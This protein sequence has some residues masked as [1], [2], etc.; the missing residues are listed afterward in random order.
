MAG[1][2]LVALVVATLVFRQS[3]LL[4]HHAVPFTQR[5]SAASDLRMEFPE[6]MDKPSVEENVITP[7]DVQ[8]SLRWDGN[9]LVFNPDA[10]LEE[11]ATYT[12]QVGRAAK[13]TN[14]TPLGRDL[15]FRFQVSGEPT[16]TARVPNADAVDVP[17]D[18]RISVVFDRPVV[19]LTQVQGK[20]AEDLLA[21]VPVR[22]APDVKGTFRWL[23]TYTLQFIPEK[24]LPLATRFTVS[25]PAGIRT[26]SGDVTA[27]DHSW[28]F[29]TERPRAVSSVPADGFR[30]AGPTT[31]LSISFN[32]EVDVGS[33]REHLRLQS[34]DRDDIRLPPEAEN[35]IKA[36]PEYEQDT[37]RWNQLLARMGSG[38]EV[39]VRDVRY[40]TTTSD[41]GKTVTDRKTVTIVPASS[42]EFHHLY[43]VRVLPGVRGLE[44]NLGSSQEFASTFATVGP[45]RV[46]QAMYEHDTIR[47]RFSNPVASGS[48]QP[49]IAL[50]P[51]PAGW[52]DATFDLDTWNE[53]RNLSIYPTLTPS[54]EYK[55]T[56]GKTVKDAFGQTLEKPHTFSFTTP[57]LPPSVSITSKGE[58][59]IFE[60]GKSPVYYVKGVNITSFEADFA[61]LTLADFLRLRKSARHGTVAPDAIAPLPGHQHWS[62]PVKTKHNEWVT[63]PLDPE[64]RA[65]GTLAPGI[66]A[67]MVQAPEYKDTS[68][69]PMTELQFFALTN[70]GLTLKYSG[71]RALVWATDLQ[72]GNP[73]AGAHVA[74][75]S[76]T[77]R[78]PVEGRTDANGFFETAIN[79]PDFATGESY[80]WIPEFWVTAEKDGDFAFVGSDWQD[81]IRPDEFGYWQ[82]FQGLQS[83]PLQMQSF[84]Y[85][86]RPLYA[87]GD[88]VH[89]KGVVRM[90]D[91]NGV[92]RLP[93]AARS[94]Q[95]TVRDENGTEVY[96]K[97]LPLNAFGSFTDSFPLSDK[98]ALGT[99]SLSMTLV[100]DADTSRGSG[101][102]ASF[103]VLAYRKPEY[104]VEVDVAAPD[105]FDRE[106]AQAQVK[107]SYYFGAPMAGAKVQWRAQTTDWFFNRYT[108]GWYS[109]STEDAWCWRDCERE[110]G[111]L[112]EG[113]GT[114]DAAGTM[115]VRVPMS[116]SDKA[117]SQILTI[118]ADVTDANNQ[119][120]SARE[121]VPVH[122]SKVYVGVRTS[123]YVVAPGQKARIDVVTVGIDGSAAPNRRVELA[124]FD[125]KWITTRKKGVDGEYYYDNE[126]ED[127]FLSN[128]SITTGGNGKGIGEFLIDRG[129][130]M[131][132]VATV[133][134]EDGREAKASTSVYAWSST[135]VNW[136]HANNDRLVM[137]VD[138]PEYRVGDIA[139]LLVKSPFQG[140]GVKALVTVERE[141]VMT[142]RVL[143]VTSNAQPIEV[144][145]TD[146]MI[147]NAFVSV[148][149]IKPREGET[150]DK[151]TGL[152]TGA[153]AFRIGY[154]KLNVE[155]KSKVLSVKVQTDK[156]TY[157][158]GETVRVKL[159]TADAT[160]KPAKAELSLGVVDMSLLALTGF[161]MPDPV[162]LFYNE[163]GLGV[164]TAEMLMYLLERY[165]PG[166][167][168][169][170][171][172]ALE[173][174]K[175]GDFRDTAYWN[176]VILTDE[177]GAASLTFKLPDNLTTWKLLAVGSTQKNL[178]GAGTRDVVETKHVIVRPVRPRFAVRG[179]E[180]QLGAIIHNFLPT[181]QTFRVTLTGSGFTMTGKAVQNVTL[182]PDAQQKLLF[183]V[184]ITG[185]D[186]AVLN[187]RAESDRGRDEIEERIPVYIFATP[188]SVTTTGVITEGGVTEKV[189]I[190]SATDASE[191]TLTLSVA[192]T[193]ATYLP[194]GL[195]YLRTYPYGCAEQVTSSFYGNVALLSLSSIGV[196]Q[197]I[198]RRTLEHQVRTA[199][200]KLHRFQRGDGGF[201]YWEESEQSS[202]SLTAYIVEALQV[203]RQQGFRVDDT[204]L[205]RAQSYLDNALRQL[206]VATSLDLSTRTHIAYV[207]AEGG[208]LDVNLLA[209]L[210]GKR[211][212]LPLFARAWLAMAY[213]RAG[214]KRA[215][216]MLK[217]IGDRAIVDPRGTHF[218][219]KHEN[220]YRLVM[221]TNERTTAL[222]LKAFARIDS[223]H[224]L[225]PTTLRYLLA[226]RTDGHWGTTQSTV[227]S[228]LAMMEFLR[229]TAELEA[230]ETALARMNGTEVL[231]QDFSKKNILDRAEV[232]R[233]LS[234]LP[235]GKEVLVEIGKSGEGR[236]YYDL[237]LSYLYTSPEIAPLEQG[238]S[239][240][241]EMEPVDTGVTGVEVGRNYR[242]RLTMTVPEDRH[243]VAAE[244][245]LPAGF[246]AIDTHLQTSQQQ[247]LSE[248]DAMAE[249]ARSDKPASTGNASWYF[250]HREF[251]D[252]RVFLFA[253]HL[254]AGVYEYEYLVRAT[255]PGRF[256]ERPARIYE[257]YY[258]ETFGQ[259]SGQWITIE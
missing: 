35:A 229:A 243:F 244:S 206:N 220:L 2:L 225:V 108:D 251:R 219:E 241:R 207:L 99:Y 6:T 141:H 29:E 41:E 166:S 13:R 199:L 59:G 105:Y 97:T 136:P 223:D 197:S 186:A 21:G 28:Q 73:V 147:P 34:R 43:A 255:T 3:T 64:K 98:A 113:T 52:K 23:S 119:V 95:V 180:V 235:R 250:H 135:Y 211:Q 27:A 126:A 67:L 217:E 181:A 256:Q 55:V 160:G 66:Y 101:G 194:G 56:V 145:V 254:P 212:D 257:M 90:R 204:V 246:E 80:E 9:T 79:L 4:R 22:V 84:L 111:F 87:A 144:P 177:S 71:S 100:P 156:E 86:E 185:P 175:R 134:D 65:G 131:V 187:F 123:D 236:L 138:K 118:E 93:D 221:N 19:P 38:S 49:S 231:R 248:A 125:R 110:M 15:T 202:P 189:L 107:G 91:R 201:G 42:L 193:I 10:T 17:D 158:P 33:V 25:V 218:E 205:S 210:D 168:G 196:P 11:N 161:S 116:L 259:T 72:T 121:S 188:Q 226:V 230:D 183:P 115:T 96:G 112:T 45:L 30:L 200:Q 75:H 184:R 122:K 74:F 61:P 170:G 157:L 36:R 163:R 242:I 137:E 53:S 252:D 191:G 1:G 140:K 78:T 106:T 31:E 48:L 76:L 7:A 149:I 109:F 215:A 104:R 143:D 142:H 240:L 213:Q 182:K 224:P 120:V 68:R 165:K 57:E 12:F 88:T 40:G 92:L 69:N 103:E 245:P 129:G 37:E 128:T 232:V 227:E 198:N 233:A 159:Q 77:G 249:Q 190:P 94:A 150:F 83:A 139:K 114:L 195:E 208:K 146:E 176:P 151:E 164:Q 162:E 39:S 172:G 46:D 117:V 81:G 171:G 238:I 26:V 47:V 18:A 192:P 14:G 5:V 102:W 51:V 32:Q 16:V 258:P 222:V 214:N 130:Q 173:E 152:D 132:M 179:D 89:F 70:I 85:T 228:V 237:L 253:E 148:V 169:G 54:T 133:K 216:T 60:R 209:P 167:K 239:I 50:A 58:F 44:G 203:T 153:P 82:D 8:G 154:V 234:E 174:R 62:I 20:P 155:R 127:T 63:Q 178:F 247:L 124:L 24:L